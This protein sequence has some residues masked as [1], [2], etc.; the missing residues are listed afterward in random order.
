MS[1]LFFILLFFI[2]AGHWPMQAFAANDPA[3]DTQENVPRYV[4]FPTIIVNTS[5]GIIYNG[6]F[7]LKLQLQVTG[8][9]AYNQ[10]E[11]L[12]PQLQDALTQATYR[13]GQ[14]YIDPRKPVPWAR[15]I[16]ELNAAV[17]KVSPK[18]PM[19]VLIVEATTRAT[20]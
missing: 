17:V 6:L 20:S 11:V 7:A 16:R 2:S 5:D 10:S 4:S 9:T 18:I 1:R 3:D 12:R 15:L 13:L 19:R 14:M 8:A